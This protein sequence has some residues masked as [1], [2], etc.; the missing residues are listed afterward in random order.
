MIKSLL[1]SITIL[2]VVL[3][4]AVPGMSIAGNG[5][6]RTRENF[7][8]AWRF[9]LG[10]VNEAQIPGYNDSQWRELNLPH[11]WS[12]EGTFSKDNPA[13]VGGGALPGGIGWYRKTFTVPAADQGKQ[14]F[15]DFD[16]VYRD[17]QVWI[18]GHYLGMRPYGYSSFRYELTP[19]LHYGDQKN[20]IAVRVDNSKQ[21]NSRWY[22]GSGIYRNVWLVTTNKIHVGHWGT[23][24]TTPMVNDQNSYVL[25]Q[26][27]VR[28]DENSS[29]DV[30]LRTLIYDAS[31]NK[32]AEASATETIPADSVVK[33]TQDV[34]VQSPHL[35]S[36]TDPYLYKAVSNVVSGP[37]T[38]D[39]YATPFG[40][41]YFRFDSKKGFF[42]NGEH[43]KIRGVCD[44]HD[45]GPLGAAI[46]TRA[47][48]RQFEIL[49]GMGV[50]AL[51]TSHNPP[52]PELLNLA[53]RMGIL[54]MDEAFDMWKKGKTKYDYHLDWDKWHKRD[55]QDMVLRDRNHPS[56]II[57]SIGNEIPEQGS[58]TGITIARELAGIVRNL[59]TTRPIT[60][61]LNHPSPDNY[62]IRSGALDLIGFSYHQ[63]TY[64]DFPKEFPGKKFIGSETTSAL[65]TRGHYDM[66]SDSIRRWPTRWDR[67]FTSGNTDNTVS[68]Y[69][70]VS[71]PWGSTHEET[72][73]LIEKYDYLSG[74]FIWTGFDYLGEPTPYG[75]PSRSSYFGIVDLA[76]F[77][78]DS[79]YLYKS[80]WTNNPVLH[81][82]PHWN[83][84]KGQTVDV[85]AYTNCDEVEL[86]LNGKSLGTRK[87]TG[88]KMHLMWRVTYEPG[89]LKAVGRKDGNVILTREIH[90]AGKPARIIL[91]AD[92]D[93]IDADGRDLSFVTV[94]VVDSKGNMVP[95]ADNLIRFHLSG[96]GF[97]AGVG[98]GNETDHE[99][100]KANYRKAFNGLCLAI[101]Q[102]NGKAGEITLKATGNGLRS[103][104][105]QIHAN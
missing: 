75:W 32:V 93:T 74:M 34:K 44:H 65:E 79:Y 7:D 49:K 11:D 27:Q 99:P 45:L 26:T 69:D 3:L 14:V 80:L 10:D 46:N 20:V 17:S 8:Q 54:V 13:G 35:W 84:K 37:D 19:Y 100:F 30:T 76:G 60:S 29:R 66:P 59:D 16:G 4:L 91:S 21:P 23:Y 85:W 40:I 36:T 33:Y 61:N 9:H 50:N 96:D 1:N 70:N 43:L 5:H 28:N 2:S 24:I 62:L 63:N 72:L 103:Q 78:K 89:T 77:P 92:R 95:N 88:D 67:P 39:Q 102:S 12:I 86:F 18:N 48:Q 64:T 81:I 41:R 56:I 15:V 83:W 73:K 58:P 90:T 104:S 105:I 53:D 82:F 51:R 94:K 6:P 47:I 71:A 55:L 97:I 57:W 31:G 42:L 22:S 38:V 68:A 98:N 101:I 25:I 87:M 52:A